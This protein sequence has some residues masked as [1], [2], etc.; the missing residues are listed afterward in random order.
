[1]SDDLTGLI[2]HWYRPELTYCRHC[3]LLGA[4]ELGPGMNM[5]H[6]DCLAEVAEEVAM[7]GVRDVANTID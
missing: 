4:S 2:E 5:Y 1:M 7:E 3:G 6:A